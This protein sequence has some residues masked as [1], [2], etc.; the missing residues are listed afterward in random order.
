[1]PIVRGAT[2]PALTTLKPDQVST[3]PDPNTAMMVAAR[4]YF[5]S[6]TGIHDVLSHCG[7]EYLLGAAIVNRCACRCT[8]TPPVM[9]G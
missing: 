2:R 7:I 1:M 6:R 3:R 5:P 4:A 9:A 8:C